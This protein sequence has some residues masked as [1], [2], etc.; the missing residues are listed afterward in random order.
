MILEIVEYSFGAV[1]VL[2]FTVIQKFMLER[3][4]FLGLD[5]SQVTVVS[6]DAVN[7][8]PYF[9]QYSTAEQQYFIFFVPKSLE[10]TKWPT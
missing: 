6:C 9:P 5:F 7:S 8:S 4:F 3:V 10:K 1:K 2:Q